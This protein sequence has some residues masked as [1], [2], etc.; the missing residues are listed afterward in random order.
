MRE[1]SIDEL[2]S[3]AS[4][5][6]ESIW[7]QAKSVG[8]EPKI[9]LHWSAGH[10]NT[11]FDDYHVN[12]TG[13]GKLWLSA[14]LNEVLA[15]TWKRNTGSVGISLCCAYGATSSDLGSEPPT[16]AQ[17]EAMAQAI[18]AVAKGLWLT[19]DKYHVLTHGEAADNIDDIYPHEQY[20][21][22]T[23]VE[24]WDLQYLGTSESPK[25]LK[26]YDNPATGGN[27][28]RGKAN[29]Y[30]DNKSSSNNDVSPTVEATS[31]PRAK[32]FSTSEM[33]CHGKSQGHCNCTEASADNVSQRLL[34]LLDQLRENIGGALEVSCMYRCPS[35][36]EAVGGV[37]NSSHRMGTAADVQTPN[38]EHCHTPEQL[39]WYAEQ[40]P[41]DG[42]GVYNWGV[43][44]DVRNGG[45]NSRIRW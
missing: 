26:D 30:M 34:D 20:G 6:R 39:K 43:H 29:W 44:V 31:K 37:P 17:I 38:F 8:R 1:V 41:F 36:N 10:Y 42:I 28:L 45:V 18:V 23:T 35:H 21:A 15:H 4:D 32:Y 27:V 12:I 40:L 11:K 24:R 5:A 19:I 13:D 25:Y 14:D 9:Y 33:M 2:Y 16:E 3:L 22:C 7:S